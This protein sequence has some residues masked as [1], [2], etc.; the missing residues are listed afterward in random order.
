MPARG[1]KETPTP[2]GIETPHQQ[3]RYWQ[4]EGRNDMANGASLAGTWA[5][6]SYLNTAD[7][8]VFGAGLFTF[9]T[10]TDTTLTGTLDMGGG[11]VLDL[12]GTIQPATG[13]GPLTANVRGFGRAGTG[14]DGWEYDYYAFLGYQWPNGVDQVQSL[15]GTVLRAKPHNGNPA[16]VTASFI[17]VRQ[18]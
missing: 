2:S 3:F 14:T 7:Q 12:Q 18:S 10:P 11:L 15:V 9:Q 16:G 13:Q 4:P 5:Y 6:S 17:A 1:A 8:P